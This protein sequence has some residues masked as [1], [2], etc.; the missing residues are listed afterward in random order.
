M[1]SHAADYAEAGYEVLPLRGKAPWI[2]SA[3]PDGD[4]LHGV[5]KGE[6][7]REGHGVLDA[8][9]SLA[10]VYEWWKRWPQANIGVRV[11]KA[12]MVIDVDP[13]HGGLERLAELITKHG[14]LPVTRT[15]FSGRGD[16]GCHFWFL[17]PGGKPSSTKIKPGL[18][19]KDRRGYV[20][21]PPSIH[22][23]TRKPYWWAQ[24]PIDPAPIPAWL[25]GLLLP[26]EQPQ[27]PIQPP[28]LSGPTIADALSWRQILPDGWVCLDH[29]P[30]ADGARWRHP[31][32]T[33][34]V[35]ATVRHGCLFVYSD[36]TP[37]PQTQTE[38]PHG[39]TKLKA[40]ATLYYG[41]NC[42]TAY[43]AL[44]GTAA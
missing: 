34:K 19:V 23:D 30:D 2:P 32:A 15:S 33:A 17:H 7:G 1:L 40:Y 24:P 18:D 13:R 4:S 8:T 12:L 43:W 11:P 10:K 42:K 27:R 3:H 6:C 36:N 29:D 5:C 39:V 20:V 21:A 38:D 26:P 14:D 16:G 31:T 22:P 35:S 28:R 37:F 44:R 41:G 25:R 9:I